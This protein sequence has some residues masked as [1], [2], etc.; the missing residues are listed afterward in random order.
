M[1]RQTV[2]MQRLNLSAAVVALAVWL[3]MIVY[4]AVMAWNQARG[5]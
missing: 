4:G 2:L 1:S 5:Q 3:A